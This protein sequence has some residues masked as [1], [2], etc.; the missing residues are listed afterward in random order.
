MS[1]ILIGKIVYQMELA[2]NNWKM[3]ETF[4]HHTI[5]LSAGEKFPKGHSYGYI[6]QE[7]KTNFRTSRKSAESILS[8]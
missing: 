2:M 5:T 1:K 7:I 6:T 3:N 8:S 4:T